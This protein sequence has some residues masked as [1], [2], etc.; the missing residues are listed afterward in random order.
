[1]F[2]RSS[3]GKVLVSALAVSLLLSDVA[4]A[5]F[6]RHTCTN[7]LDWVNDQYLQETQFNFY[8]TTMW[9]NDYPDLI[10]D[11]D[12]IKETNPIVAPE[13]YKVALPTGRARCC[14]TEYG[15]NGRYIASV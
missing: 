15:L 13:N 10:G 5:G 4:D 1:M 11:H 8:S 12:I 14:A 9:S 6:A 3:Q 2:L 7:D